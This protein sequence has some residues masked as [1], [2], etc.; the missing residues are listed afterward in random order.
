MEKGVLSSMNTQQI[1]TTLKRRGSSDVSYLQHSVDEMI[2][3]FMEEKGIPGVSLAIV[4]AP[5]IPRVVGYGISDEKQKRLV[6]PNTMFPLGPISQAYLA[7]AIMQLFEAGKLDVEKTIGNYLPSLPKKW[8]NLT[9]LDLLRHTSGLKDYRELPAFSLDKPFTYED[10]IRLLEKEPLAFKAGH[11]FQESATDNLL[12]TKVVE[13]A[14]GMSYHAYVKALQFEALHLRHTSFVEDLPSFKNEDL[15]KSNFVHEIFKHD[16][17]YI[18]PSETAASYDANGKLISYPNKG[19]LQGYSDVY[20]S[21]GDVSYWDIALAGGVLIHEKAHRDLIYQSWT[22]E[23]GRIV[24]SVSGWHFYFHRG[25][26]AI[27]G[28]VRGY[29]SYLSR[30][31]H[32][33]ELVCVTLLANKEGVDFTNLARKIAA[34]FGDLL[35]TN[36]DDNRLYLLEG[37]FKGKEMVRRLKN[38]LEKR[39]IPLFAEFDHSANAKGVGLTL[40][41]NTVLVFGSPKA[42]TPLMVKDPSL[43]LELPLKIAVWED[44]TGSSW[45]GFKKLTDLEE[46][47]GLRDDPALKKMEALLETLAKEAAEI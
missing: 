9:I 22:D 26:M 13:T 18:D 35:S 31:T 45:V 10:A 3:S 43:A 41:P 33:E 21:S 12:L 1:H 14:S 23:E 17:A 38:A 46:G 24:P 7:V 47:Y 29:S 36:Y 20:A 42:G 5:Y 34:S 32:S 8:E 4:Q 25:L 15:T 30:F 27:R 39:D 2:S 11:G 28:S 16:G 19:V 44:A 6:S 37:Q 40:L